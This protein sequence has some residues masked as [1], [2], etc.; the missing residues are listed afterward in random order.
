[1]KLLLLL[2]SGMIFCSAILPNQDDT[3][4]KSMARGKTIYTENC[5]NCHMAKGEG[6]VET[7][8]PLAKSDYL[9]KTPA[10][11]IQAIKFGLQGPIRVNGATYDNAM[12]EPGLDEQEVADVMNYIL[13][14]WG[15]SSDKKLITALQVGDVKA[16]Q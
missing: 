6:V 15:N 1:M 8:P 3:L 13:N 7:F 2:L 10:K 12:P 9:L 14:S 5:I 11:A 4:E 16:N